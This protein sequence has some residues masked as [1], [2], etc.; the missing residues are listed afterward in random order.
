MVFKAT[1]SITSTLNYAKIPT[2]PKNNSKEEVIFRI[3][4]GFTEPSQ[5]QASMNM[6]KI[7]GQ[8]K[9]GRKVQNRRRKKLILTRSCSNA[10]SKRNRRLATTNW[11][12][13]WKNWI[14]KENRTSTRK[15]IFKIGWL[16]WMLFSI[17]LPRLLVL[18]N[19]ILEQEY[20]FNYL[21]KLKFW[22]KKI[23]ARRVAKKTRIIKKK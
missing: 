18:E 15:L 6:P 4:H 3:T 21:A 5:D 10:K 8:K 23:K 14:N 11:G 13:V 1:T 20:I 16:T 7:N 12:R 19:T 17:K 22:N 2:F 9:R